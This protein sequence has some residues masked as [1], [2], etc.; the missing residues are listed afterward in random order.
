MSK[1]LTR[2]ASLL[3]QNIHNFVVGESGP[4]W[5]QPELEVEKWAHLSP[6]LHGFLSALSGCRSHR[7]EESLVRN[8]LEQVQKALRS[9]GEASPSQVADALVRAM[10]CHILGYPVDF[11]KIYALQ[12][13]QKGNTLEK[14]MGNSQR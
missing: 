5:A 1:V 14:K 7:E 9:H 6:G 11:A 8:H 13:A 4:G 2:T 3:A 10:A 12:L